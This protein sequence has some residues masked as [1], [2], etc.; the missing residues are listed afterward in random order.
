M[1]L[2]KLILLV[3]NANLS[4]P[5]YD[6]EELIIKNRDKESNNETLTGY[7]GNKTSSSKIV[8]KC[9]SCRITVE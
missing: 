8:F 6:F 2:K 4:F 1:A 5:N 7:K 3:L 9:N